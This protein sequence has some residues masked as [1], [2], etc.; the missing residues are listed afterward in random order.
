MPERDRS[1]RRRPR[2]SLDL[3]RRVEAWLDDDAS[4]SLAGRLLSL[5]T[6]P[7]VE[8][9][10]RK[11]LVL[12]PSRV[13]YVGVG[14]VLVGG[15]GKT[16]VSI[17]IARALAQAGARASLR[18]RVAL[19]GH[20]Y[21]GRV[22]ACH[23]VSPDAS[24]DEAGDEARLAAR[25]LADLPNARV[26]VGPSRCL[27]AAFASHTADVVVFD[28]AP[29]VRAEGAR[30]LGVMA[31]PSPRSDDEARRFERLV[32]DANLVVHAESS[33]TRLSLVDERGLIRPL[34]DL[35]GLRFGLATAIARPARVR[36]ALGKLVPSAVLTLENHARFPHEDEARVDRS[37]DAWL[38]TEKGPWLGR[39]T[40]GGRPIH[41]LRHAVE[42]PHDITRHLEDFAFQAAESSVRSA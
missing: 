35:E 27:A 36:R 21:A 20:A 3:R 9:R 8:A 24:S 6:E 13:A 40:F 15:S 1:W 12:P 22:R 25:Q 32:R 4:D 16:P 31:C 17:A 29:L 37:L 19:V 11:V 30:S 18:L 33:E 38:V 2:F 23:V 5:A 39:N 26:V 10:A 7:L 42:L 41:F 14:G 34:S 28:G